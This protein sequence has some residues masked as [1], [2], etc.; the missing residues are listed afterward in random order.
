VILTVTPLSGLA[1]LTVIADA[2]RSTDAGGIAS[3]GFDFGDG[4]VSFPTPGTTA[5]HKYCLSGV[6]RLTVTVTN[7]V[8]LHSS[9]FV[10]VAVTQP[11][12]PVSC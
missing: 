3:Y 4:T 10:Y 8:G 9:A 5:S 12:N 1:P 7:N 6:Y 11:I 2:S